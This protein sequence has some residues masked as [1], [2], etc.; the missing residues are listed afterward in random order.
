VEARFEGSD[1]WV[2]VLSDH[3]VEAEPKSLLDVRFGA[4]DA[5]QFPAVPITADFIECI[6]SRRETVAPVEV[7][8]RATTIGLIGDIAMR[9]R[10]TMCWDPAAERFVGND[11]A[12]RMLS[13]A[14][15]EPWSVNSL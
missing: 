9:L 11:A 4:N 13:R 10:R 12:N 1:G 15:R 6:R 3:V 8:H 2:R 14:M 7:A 5:H